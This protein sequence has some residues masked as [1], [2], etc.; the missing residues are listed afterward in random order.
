MGPGFSGGSNIQ[1]VWR[2]TPLGL[3]NPT[4][5]L[6]Q[7]IRRILR[8]SKYFSVLRSVLL[9]QW[10]MLP[11]SISLEPPWCKEQIW[12]LPLVLGSCQTKNW[13]SLLLCPWALLASLWQMERQN[14]YCHIYVVSPTTTTPRPTPLHHVEGKL[15]SSW[16]ALS[17]FW[18]SFPTNLDST[19][20]GKR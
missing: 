18:T 4:G 17:I 15:D 10:L 7:V 14:P 20:P 6:I 13:L 12:L 3:L 11:F 8:A 2:I 1:P 9:D 16:A 5:D 19:G